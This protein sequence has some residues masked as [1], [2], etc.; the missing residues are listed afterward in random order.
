MTLF[1]TLCLRQSAYGSTVMELSK[2]I[3]QLPLL[4]LPH[5]R[6]LGTSVG[7]KLLGSWGGSL[8]SHSVAYGASIR[9]LSQ[10][11]CR[12]KCR[13][14]CHTDNLRF[15]FWRLVLLLPYAFCRR[16]ISEE[17]MDHCNPGGASVGGAPV[18]LA[19]CGSAILRKY[20]IPRIPTHPSCYLISFRDCS[21]TM[22]PAGF[23]TG[24]L[25]ITGTVGTRH[26][27]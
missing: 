25:F 14:I 2:S 13:K 10:T 26:S 9:T 27:N 15:V 16:K 11:K 8:H 6:P 22:I 18:Q 20:T 4:V 19:P 23:K 24:T 21:Y 7:G 3:C 12:K 17:I 5:L 1:P